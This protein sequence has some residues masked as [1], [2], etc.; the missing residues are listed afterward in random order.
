MCAMVTISKLQTYAMLY[1]MSPF[2]PPN[3]GT[4]LTHSPFTFAGLRTPAYGRPSVATVGFLVI[5][6]VLNL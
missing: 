5:L 4:E 1:L 2:F 3:S 6:T